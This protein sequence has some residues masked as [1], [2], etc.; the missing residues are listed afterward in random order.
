MR[1]KYFISLIDSCFGIKVATKTD[2]RHSWLYRDKIF[3]CDEH[4][5]AGRDT[6]PFD[7]ID[8]VMCNM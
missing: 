5:I 6:Q 1:V 2:S 4:P 3:K 8:K 7:E